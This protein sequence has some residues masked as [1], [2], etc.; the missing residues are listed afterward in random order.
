[1]STPAARHRRAGIADRRWGPDT[2]RG[3]PAVVGTGVVQDG[4]LVRPD[5]D[6]PARPATVRHRIPRGHPPGRSGAPAHRVAARASPSR[7]SRSAGSCSPARRTIRSTTRSAWS[8]VAWS[9]RWPTPSSDAPSRPP[10][11]S[12]RPTRRSTWSVSYLRPVTSGSVLRATG[13]VTKPGRRVGFAAA[14]IVDGD[15]HGRSPRRRAA[16][17]SWRCPPGPSPADPSAAG[18]TDRPPS[19][20]R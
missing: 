18:P 9:A 5:G 3:D 8:T 19:Y 11:R 12:V 20:C 6:R 1:M 15:G 2:G 7:R 17:W 4:D 14:E 13:T 16:A 10:C